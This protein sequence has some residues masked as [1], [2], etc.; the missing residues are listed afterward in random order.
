M[1]FNGII[2][3]DKDWH[4][5][6][7]HQLSKFREIQYKP[8]YRSYNKW[9]QN[10]LWNSRLYFARHNNWIMALIKLTIQS[11]YLNDNSV[12]TLKSYIDGTKSIIMDNMNKNTSCVNLLCSRK[13]VF[14]LDI[15]DFLEILRFM[16]VLQSLP[17]NQYVD[18][19]I[20]LDNTDIN[21]QK[22]KNFQNFIYFLLKE[23]YSKKTVDN[24]MIKI[25]IPLICSLFSK[26]MHLP[27][28]KIDYDYLYKLFDE[29]FAVSDVMIHFVMEINYL[30]KRNSLDTKKKTTGSI[31]FIEFM[32][33]YIE[34][35][36]KISYTVK[37]NEM[38]K[39]FEALEFNEKAKIENNLPILYPLDFSFVITKIKHTRRMKSTTRP[40]I[41]IAEIRCKNIIK[42]VSLIIKKD[43]TLR[44]ERIV[45]CLTTLL[46]IKLKQQ[47]DNGKF[48]AFSEFPTYDIVMLTNNLGIIEVV[49]NSITL[50]QVSDEH[51]VSLQNYVLT[52]NESES[53]QSVKTRF[54][55]TMSI[56]NS[57]AYIL[58]LGDRHMDNIMIT[59]K[60]EI[61][62]IDFGYIMQNPITNIW[63]SPN[64]KLTSD[65]IDF[66]GGTTSEYY[67]MFQR[68]VIKSHEILRMHK[69]I[70]TNY[71]EILGDEEYVNWESFKVKLENRLMNNLT[72]SE[73][74]VT[75]IKEIET[76][77]SLTH[78]I[79]DMFHNVRQQWK[80][81]GFGLF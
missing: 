53:I 31:N 34:E 5:A 49:P 9:E 55:Q 37:I 14:P 78:N 27:K 18:R 54:T 30:T 40:V 41:I 80:N 70:I 48:D 16:C 2:I 51:H 45:S 20:L 19:Y 74:S 17:N 71:Y 11:H 52:R 47:S 68:L 72:D 4:A 77:N 73:I 69:N 63:G 24:N 33:S 56:S 81:Y 38:T 35:K 8:P 62:H 3:T 7:I 29:I 59:S 43:A 76:S 50:R 6:C 46:Q 12:E 23:V 15:L 75:L 58:G 64:I 44:K 25:L 60:G 36:I 13:C 26:L 32:S 1:N 57:I 66:L 10:M 22:K 61:F 39:V 21:S 42:E 79:G 65:I 67:T 28:Q